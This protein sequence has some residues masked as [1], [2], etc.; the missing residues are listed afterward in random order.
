MFSVVRNF[1][2]TITLFLQLNCYTNKLL[3]VHWKFLT[4]IRKYNIT[5]SYKRTTG[6]TPIC[7]QSNITSKLKSAVEQSPLQVLT[8][9][10]L[11]H[12]YI[13]QIPQDKAFWLNYLA[14]T[15]E[16]PLP[17]IQTNWSIKSYT[18][19][20]APGSHH[21][22]NS[23]RLNCLSPIWQTLPTSKVILTPPILCCV[24]NTAIA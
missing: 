6:C 16:L 1:K 11:Q 8:F 12:I 20:S 5:V 23:L 17:Q 21:I 24:R 10:L 3:E 14:L 18:H 15:Y 13:F 22:R 4:W 2:I 19:K 7:R 9:T